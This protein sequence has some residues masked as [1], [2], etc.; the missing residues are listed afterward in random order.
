MAGGHRSQSPDGSWTVQVTDGPTSLGPEGVTLRVFKGEAPV[1]L[2]D[3]PP[4]LTFEA[5]LTGFNAR[6]SETKA[7]WTAGGRECHLQLATDDAPAFLMVVPSDNQ[8][9]FSS[10]SPP[11]KAQQP[12]TDNTPASVAVVP[13]ENDVRFSAHS[14]PWNARH[15]D[16]LP[17]ILFVITVVLWAG[18]SWRRRARQ[19][20]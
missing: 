14:P 16:L 11:W 19:T 13:S 1:T 3:N 15:V 18:Y 2:K 7:E 5:P 6:L 8:V 20:P 9:F 10:H 4:V 12:A 17:W